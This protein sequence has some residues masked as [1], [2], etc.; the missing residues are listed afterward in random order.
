MPRDSRCRKRWDW[1][2]RPPSGWSHEDEEFSRGFRRISTPQ[3]KTSGLR[4]NADD[5]RMGNSGDRK[6]VPTLDELC[7]DGDP[8]VADVRLGS[9]E[10]GGDLNEAKSFLNLRSAQGG[11]KGRKES[12]RGGRDENR[13]TGGSIWAIESLDRNAEDTCEH[14]HSAYYFALC[15][16]SLRS[17]RLKACPCTLKRRRS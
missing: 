14:A 7:D 8:V 9:I 13:R 2:I 5:R 11:A 12:R 4:R 17:S 15:A 1:L 3:A 10:S 6:F 16:P